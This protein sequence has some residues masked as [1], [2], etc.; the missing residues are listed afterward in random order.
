VACAIG[1]SV[2]MSSTDF[3]FKTWFFGIY[4]NFQCQKSLKNQY[5]K[6]NPLNPAHQDLSNNTKST[7]QFLG[8][9]QLRFNS[10]FSE[11]SFN[12][13]ELLRHKSKRHETKPIH[14][15][16]GRAFQRHQE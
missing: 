7:F 2:T 4:L 3:S 9:F 5:L 16:S 12:I 13:Q 10:I 14:S 8:N 6:L 1:Q 15:S 11:K